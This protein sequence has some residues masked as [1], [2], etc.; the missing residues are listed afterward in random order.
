MAKPVRARK[1]RAP[2]RA[3]ARKGKKRVT[4]RASRAALPRKPLPSRRVPAHRT[5]TPEL[6]ANGRDRYE[7]TDESIAS[8]AADFGIHHHSLSRLAKRER[9]VRHHRPARGLPRPARL[10]AEAERLEAEVLEETVRSAPAADAGASPPPLWG[11]AR[12]GARGEDSPGGSTVTATAIPSPQGGGE[13]FAAPPSD[14]DAPKQEQ[15]PSHAA[16]IERLRRAVLEEIAAVES[17]RAALGKQPQRPLEAARTAQALS[18]L[19][20]TV[21]K[22]QRMQ[23]GLLETGSDYD[24]DIP[25]DLD[26]FREDLARRIAAFMESRPD[27]EAVVEAAGRPA[28]P[29][30]S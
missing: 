28:D 19:T 2:E 16:T 18:S 29:A 3:P 8:I 6:L 23:C 22:L 1:A 21:N 13:A 10:L 25:A 9:W 24:D 12:E 26:A 14:N 20:E 30:A 17:M 11:R 15:P 5:Y 4:A 7:H 27:D